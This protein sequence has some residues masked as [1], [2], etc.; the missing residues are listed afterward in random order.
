MRPLPWTEIEQYRVQLVGY[1]TSRGDNHG[2]FVIPCRG[3]KLRVMASAGESGRLAYGTE[4]AWDHVSV[5]LPNRCP[6]WLEMS[7]VKSLFWSDEETVMELHVPATDHLNLAPTCLHLW[8]PLNVKIPLPPN[9]MVAAHGTI[10]DNKDYF[11]K[12]VG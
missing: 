9:D 2:L 5:S 12:K 11:N 6:N 3:M 4:Y 8:R 7:Y 1:E 10:K